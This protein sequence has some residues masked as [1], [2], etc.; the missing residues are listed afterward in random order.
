ME[1]YQKQ[2]EIIKRGVVNIYSESELIDRLKENRPLRVKLG[3]D[4]TAPD[5]HLGHTVVLK[6]LRQFQDLGH[7]A[8][9]IIGDFTALIGDPA[10]REKTRP[11]LTSEEIERNAQ[12]Y[13]DQVGRI[14]NL[15]TLEILKNSQ[16]LSKLQM[17]DILKLASCVTLAR[18]IERDDFAVRL[19]NKT[20]IRLHELLYPIMQGYDS[21]V[22]KADIELGGTDQ[23]FN[24][25]VGR[26]F[27]RMAG[28]PPQIAI[29]TPLL[30]GLDGHVKMSKSLGNH[31][32]ITEPP[33][34]MFS[35]IMSIPDY[36]MEEYYELLTELPLEEIKAFIKTHPRD[37]KV[38]L[39]VEI[40]KCFYGEKEASK[41][42]DLFDEIFRYKRTPSQMPEFILTPADLKNGKIWLPRLLT[43][44]NMVSSTS[45]ARRLISQGGVTIDEVKI[46]DPEI[47]LEIRDGM[48]L[49]VGKKN[50]F[51]RIKFVR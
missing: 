19:K 36:L 43:Y 29:T 23:T 24:L 30:V 6:K 21:V 3:V 35:K 22:V 34:E 1:N 16:W 11:Q 12:T 7:Q 2:L 25:L 32:G 10:G 5:I 44:C 47:E 18:F 39:G 8:I 26:D 4:P 20:P 51:C 38:R 27:Q 50:R 42:A 49:K 45:E 41:A 40:V 31:I 37:A 33:F 28:L 48:V 17:A 15:A 46:T 13:L 14:L 9:L